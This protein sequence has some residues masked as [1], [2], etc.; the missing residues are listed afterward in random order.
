[1]VATDSRGKVVA[2][3]VDLDNLYVFRGNDEQ[4]VVDEGGECPSPHKLAGW[5]EQ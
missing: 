5:Y 3:A 1:M 4:G 2:R